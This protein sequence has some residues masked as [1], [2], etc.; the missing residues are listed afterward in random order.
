MPPST[1]VAY[2]GEPGAYS[3][4][5]AHEAFKPTG[6]TIDAIGH[7]SFEEVFKS[8]VDGNADYA[9]VPVENTL[10]G[11]IHVN[12]DLMLR[13]HDV[14]VIGEH[15]FRVRHCMLALPGVKKADVKHAM[16]HPQ[17]L[18]QTEQYLRAAGIVAN[19]AYDTA[20][21]AKIVR[22]KGLRDTVAIASARAAE[23]H[24][25]EVLDY[26]IEDDTNN[27]TRFLILS[28]TPVQLPENTPA[29]TSVVFIPQ[30][31]E[32]GV[33]HKALSCFAQRDID[34][35][36]IESRPFRGGD[37]GLGAALLAE[38]PARR[39][40][41]RAR[42]SKENVGGGC[43]RRAPAPSRSSSTPSTS[44]PS[45]SSRRPSA[46]TPSAPRT[47]ATQGP[48]H[49]PARRHLP[50]ARR[51]RP[52][53]RR[54]AGRRHRR[55]RRRRVGIRARLV[56]R[57]AAPDRHHR[58][59]HLWPV[60]RAALPAARARDLG[61]EPLGLLGA[62]G[63]DGR[64]VRQDRRRPRQGR[65][66]RPPHLGLDPSCSAAFRACRRSCSRAYSSRTCSR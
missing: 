1:R 27:F 64:H 24:G 60:P 19:P 29:K 54:R 2:Q 28:R 5:A 39:S 34:L 44:T 9:A 38:E 66:R 25:L 30:R 58:L 49:L 33:L 11:S 10:G 23:V 26:G 16:S 59:R 52:R 62:G 43:R 14:H 55:I 22:E 56:A 20:G 3:E 4:A 6:L 61:A 36:K 21:S 65:R 53:R 31:N 47:R 8:L 35:S 51:S 42:M 12:Y 57:L 18:A 32:V 50:A 15:S 48:R 13:N 46:A 40:R 63:V 41:R 45:S 37:V 7:A 17:A